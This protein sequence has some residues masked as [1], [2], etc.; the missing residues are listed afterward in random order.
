M[1]DEYPPENS[2]GNI[3]YKVGYFNLPKNRLMKLSTQ[4]KWRLQ[5]GKRLYNRYEATYIIGILDNGKFGKKTY[6]EIMDTINEIKK[7]SQICDANV[8]IIY[9]ETKIINNDKSV[10]AQLLIKKNIVS[11]K[12]NEF[13]I[14]FLGDEQSGKTTTL[15]N[16]YLNRSDD[17]KGSGRFPLLKSDNEQITGRTSCINQ[18][19]CG[20]DGDRF[21][22]PKSSLLGCTW[23]EIMEMSDIVIDIF[24]TCGSLTYMKHTISSI[25]TYLPNLN[26]IF[27]S[28]KI[29][30]NT[31]FYIR[32]SY[33]LGIPFVIILTHS[34][35]YSYCI[36]EIT[37]EIILKT[38][39]PSFDIIEISNVTN[40]GIYNL[41]SII[42]EKTKNIVHAT[43]YDKL[44]FKTLFF[45]DKIYEPMDIFSGSMIIGNIY[46]NNTY[47]LWNL[48][49]YPIIIKS[50]RKKK[51]DYDTFYPTEI[52][53]IEIND[54]LDITN[55]SIICDK[56][57]TPIIDDH[58]CISCDEILNGEGLLFIGNMIHPIIIINNEIKFMKGK[59][60][61]LYCFCVIRL[62]DKYYFVYIKN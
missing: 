43:I 11:H 10:I 59:T 27:V 39:V 12:L 62:K 42:K 29:T 19:I 48:I 28:E 36:D 51:I 26:F 3:E 24:D 40:K 30:D 35:V 32:L 37:N 38:H 55:K 15:A 49:Y 4:I 20:F 6:E 52:G 18:I 9:I 14:C 13:K 41:I 16:I 5:E 25:L 47:Q 60:I 45:T 33:K 17:G 58:C 23:E 54:Q 7:A 44:N 57:D 34:D 31:L 53:S 22:N 8:E 50:I 56:F 61:I 2:I 1:L 21:I 46:I